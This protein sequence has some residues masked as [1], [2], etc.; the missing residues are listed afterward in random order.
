MVSLI[1]FMMVDINNDK[2]VSS[3]KI[4]TVPQI[5]VEWNSGRSSGGN[6][7]CGRSLKIR[8]QR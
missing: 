2:H 6:I 5:S 1:I 8:I 7:F 3:I 4:N